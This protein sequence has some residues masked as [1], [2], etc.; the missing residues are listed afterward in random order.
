MYE[1]DRKF[2]SNIARFFQEVDDRPNSSVDPDTMEDTTHMPEGNKKY[3]VLIDDNFHYG[4]GDTPILGGSY[5]SYAKAVRKAKRIVDSS[6]A[7]H[8][9]K[10][11]SEADLCKQ[12]T[13]FGDDPY[14][15]PDDGDPS[16]SARTYARE[17]Y[18]VICKGRSPWWRWN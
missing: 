8:Y 13:F 10:G 5:N 2:S 9:K 4:T 18:P 17:R 14:V 1:K 16:F 11:M 3:D 6:L 7:E 15:V 12:Y